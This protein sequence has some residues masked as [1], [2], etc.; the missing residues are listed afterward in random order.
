MAFRADSAVSLHVRAPGEFDDHAATFSNFATLPLDQVHTV[1]APGV[2][3]GS[4]YIGS[5][6]AVWTGT[7]FASPIAAG[8]VALC[9]ASNKCADRRPE[10]II[11]KVVADAAAYNQA[12][13]G[14]GF[15]GDPLRP[16]TSKYY[17]W[18]I[19]AGLY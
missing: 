3:L 13:L 7:S 4:T 10:A 11:R 19:R 14:Y 6:Y 5:Q 15:L 16:I 2:C 1:S 12:N 8:T 17:G 9:I 18:L